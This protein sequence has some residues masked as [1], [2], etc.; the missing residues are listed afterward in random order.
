ME[1]AFQTLG[2]LRGS[3]QEEFSRESDRQNCP[4]CSQQRSTLLS[5]LR[6]QKRSASRCPRRCSP[7]PTRSSNDAS[8]C[9]G[10]WVRYWHFRDVPPTSAVTAVLGTK[11]DVNALLDKSTARHGSRFQ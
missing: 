9:C 4:S 8:L 10:A 5:T 6:L 11:A 1:R 2:D 7:A 3:T